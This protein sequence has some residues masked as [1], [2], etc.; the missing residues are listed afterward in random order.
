MGVTQSSP[1]K[2]IT[3]KDN[4][5]YLSD[6]N[7]NIAYCNLY[8]KERMFVKYGGCTKN[9]P[10]IGPMRSGVCEVNGVNTGI[11]CASQ[12]VNGLFLPVIIPEEI[13]NIKQY[14]DDPLFK[15]AMF[16]EDKIKKLMSSIINEQ[17]GRTYKYPEDYNQ[18]IDEYDVA[19]NIIP[20]LNDKQ[21]TDDVLSYLEFSA[22]RKE[23]RKRVPNLPT[24]SFYRGNTIPVLTPNTS[25]IFPS[26]PIPA[27]PIVPTMAPVFKNI[28]PTTSPS[29]PSLSQPDNT[30]LWIGIS[31]FCIILLTICIIFIVRAIRLNSESSYQYGGVAKKINMKSKVKIGKR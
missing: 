15:K 1:C 3:K 21:M 19:L 31:A 4:V 25:Y 11:R 28:G 20:G 16:N 10:C 27:P 8:D 13:S 6:T 5:Y 12:E 7:K 26:S 14:F 17:T 29:P 18:F 24:P 22:L 30:L 2:F 9:T 23:Q